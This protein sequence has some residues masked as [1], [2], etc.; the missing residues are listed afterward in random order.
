MNLMATRGTVAVSFEGVE[1]AIDASEDETLLFAGLHAGL[2][3]PYECASGGCGSCRAQLIWG[4]VTSRWDGATGL[5][6]RDRRKGDRILMC[7]SIPL[8]ACQILTP[9]SER[10]SA[11]HEPRP[12]RLTGLL[13]DRELLCTDTARFVFTVSDAVNYLPGQF[14]LLEFPD[15]VRRAYS[16]TRPKSR[17]RP[18]EIELLVRSKPGGAASGWL[19]DRIEVGDVVVVE[20]P[21]GKAYSQSP[22]DRPV[23]CL[24]GGTGLA[25]ILAIAEHLR[26]ESPERRVDV[27]VG[28]RRIEDLVL[29]DRLMALSD[30][31]THVVSVIE[32]TNGELHPLLGQTREGLAL[33]HLADDWPELGGHDVYVAGP[34]PMIDAA[35]RK[36]VRDGT[37]S[38]DRVFFD[39]FIA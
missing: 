27:Y 33:D 31:T 37:A 11:R 38:A 35:L 13:T 18:R 6:E 21:Y 1:S 25:P 32:E 20:G 28:S 2:A 12:E 14:V 29:G 26:S 3:L 5:S 16:M 39:R 22:T 19:F 23:V 30:S 4:S 8:E 7:Q 24:A 15:G 34:T 10:A 17:E 36:L 9:I